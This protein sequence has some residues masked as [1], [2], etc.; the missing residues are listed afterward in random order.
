MTFAILYKAQAR[1]S[2]SFYGGRAG[3]GFLYAT[4]KSTIAIWIATGGLNIK[5]RIGYSR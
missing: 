5:L 1:P 3:H 2:F 4:K